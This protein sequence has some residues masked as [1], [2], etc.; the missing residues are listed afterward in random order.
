MM[1]RLFGLGLAVAVA[2]TVGSVSFAADGGS[3]FKSKCSTCH[4]AEGQG[5]AMAPAFK[6]NAFVKNSA[7]ADIAKVIKEGRNG[8]DKKYKEFAIGMPKQTLND[9]E[10]KAVIS[11][12][13]GMAG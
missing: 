3:V 2:I 5:T 12:I 8:A 4:G 6:G 13:K 1:K 11:Q 7:E 9:D 10:L